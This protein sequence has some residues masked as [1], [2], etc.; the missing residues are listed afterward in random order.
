M[1]MTFPVSQGSQLFKRHFKKKM[2]F[3]SNWLTIFS[4][5][6][7]LHTFTSLTVEKK[8]LLITL[9]MLIIYLLL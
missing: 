8:E 4:N 7:F 9:Y 5:D 2:R 1:S 6:R 3:P